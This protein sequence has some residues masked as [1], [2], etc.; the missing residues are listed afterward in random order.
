M[1]SPRE[2]KKCHDILKIDKY[3]VVHKK[4]APRRAKIAAK[5]KAVAERKQRNLAWYRTKGYKK[6]AHGRT[7]LFSQKK[8]I[9]RPAAVAQLSAIPK[10]PKKKKRNRKERGKDTFGIYKDWSRFTLSL[11]KQC[12]AFVET[13]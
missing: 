12:V 2:S 3:Y 8:R 4:S 11:L 7:K 1:V 5:Q 13:V 10:V 9:L 6:N